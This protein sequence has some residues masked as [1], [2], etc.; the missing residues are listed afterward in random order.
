[1]L[2]TS[3]DHWRIIYRY[4]QVV[5]HT[6]WASLVVPCRRRH[7]FKCSHVGKRNRRG[8]NISLENICLHTD[9][10][11]KSTVQ[12]WW[13]VVVSTVFSQ[14]AGPVSSS[15]VETAS[16]CGVCIFSLGLWGFPPGALVSPDS[17]QKHVLAQYPVCAFDQ[18]HWWRSSPWVSLHSS[19]TAPQR[20]VGPMQRTNFTVNHVCDL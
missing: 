16:Q 8:G 5:W 17:P 15:Q 4:H 10:A 13:H 18:M 14:Q 12:L 6:F 2:R 20:R 1:M 7:V 9:L 3:S 11:L 19:S